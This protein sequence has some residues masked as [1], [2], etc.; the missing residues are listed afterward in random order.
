MDY[1]MNHPKNSKQKV[2][3]IITPHFTSKKLRLKGVKSIVQVCSLGT[4]LVVIGLAQCPSCQS[5]SFASSPH[6][7]LQCSS[8]SVLATWG[9]KEEREVDM[10][11]FSAGVRW[12]SGPFFIS[13]R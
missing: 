13:G 3:I 2:V 7:S 6:S 1:L 5:W 12:L 8:L 11:V 4:Q 10:G 9:K